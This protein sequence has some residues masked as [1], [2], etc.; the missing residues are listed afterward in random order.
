M[1][2]PCESGLKSTDC[3]LLPDGFWYKNPTPFT[4]QPPQ[5]GFSHPDCYLFH[6]EDCSTKMS[7]EHYVSETALKAVDDILKVSV[8]E[9]R[10]ALNILSSVF[11]REKRD[12]LNILSSVFV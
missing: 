4:P 12:A 8:R 1:N 7:D 2:C 6:T 9:K 3:C 5:T 10:D 11:V